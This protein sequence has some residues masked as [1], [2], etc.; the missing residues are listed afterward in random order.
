[1]AETVKSVEELLSPG[2]KY[3]DCYFTTEPYEFL[4]Y[5][6]P[7]GNTNGFLGLYEYTNG[8]VPLRE[9]FLNE[10]GDEVYAAS[11]GAIVHNKSGTI[12]DCIEMP[13]RESLKQ[14]QECGFIPMS[15]LRIH[16]VGDGRIIDAVSTIS[17]ILN[18]E[19]HNTAFFNEDRTKKYV[20]ISEFY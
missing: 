15:M 19:R 8:A 3:I 4:E 6:M 9:F 14:R 17:T 5:I 16:R 11:Q 12:V 7:E 1:M 10:W 13:I 20:K 2:W 18:E